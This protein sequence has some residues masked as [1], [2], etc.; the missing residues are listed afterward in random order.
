MS[1]QILASFKVRGLTAASATIATVTVNYN[2]DGT[3][4]FV[5]AASTVHVYNG[6]CPPINLLLQLAFTGAG[7]LAAIDKLVI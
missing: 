5:D 1:T 4:D 7:G 6:D 2:S 3:W